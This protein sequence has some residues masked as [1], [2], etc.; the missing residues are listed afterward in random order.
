VKQGRPYSRSL[1]AK[2][3][4]AA[5]GVWVTCR[6]SKE[7]ILFEY[8]EG[9]YWGETF[10]GIEEAARGYLGKR[11]QDLSIE[12]SFFLIERLC[13]PNR[14][15]PQR[16]EVIL[17]RGS[18]ANVL[19][20]YNSSAFALRLFYEKVAGTGRYRSLASP[21]SVGAFVEQR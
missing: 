2:I 12:E 13:S 4:Q 8:L 9:V 18:I 5:F 10:N 7:M 11:P 17:G 19:A 1:Y 20:T 6:L 3:V 21:N 15:S 14:P 16:V